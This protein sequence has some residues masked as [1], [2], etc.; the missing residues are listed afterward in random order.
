MWCRYAYASFQ[1]RTNVPL[2]V[3]AHFSLPA[4]LAGQK[5]Q[6][7]GLT[8]GAPPQQHALS[9]VFMILRSKATPDGELH[10]NAILEH[11]DVR[12]CALFALT[13][14][15]WAKHDIAGGDLP[16]GLVDRAQLGGSAPSHYGNMLFSAD[17]PGKQKSPPPGVLY[18][19]LCPSQFDKQF[20][21]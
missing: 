14:Y 20:R 10:Y 9:L 2:T 15:L 13:L 11:V 3:P 1:R 12:Q 17:D 7:P 19:K 4:S 5:V 16:V 21:Q 18:P 6:A 8:E